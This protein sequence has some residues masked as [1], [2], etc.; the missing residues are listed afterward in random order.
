MRK[1]VKFLKLV[2][3]S[4]I[5]ISSPPK[6]KILIYDAESL[7]IFEK[8]FNE[9][10]YFVLYSRKSVIYPII[11][12]KS[13]FKY[14]SK[15]NL[16]NYYIDLI[17]FVSPEFAFT[18]IDNETFFWKL[19]FL[20]KKKTTTFFIQNGFRNYAHDIFEKLDNSDHDKEKHKVDYY[21]VFSESVKK[22]YEKYMNG[23]GIVIGSFKNNHVPV[24]K[25]NFKQDI[26]FVSEFAS[27]KYFKPKFSSE[28][29]WYPE[30]FFLPI[31]KRFAE[32][33][34]LNL[35]ILGKLNNDKSLKDEEKKF[36]S[37]IIGE[38]G[39]DYVESNK[40]YECYKRIDE[41]KFIIFVSS[42]LGYEAI[43]RNKP[44]AALCARN[45]KYNNHATKNDFNFSWPANI[46]DKGSFW[47]NDCNEE[48]VLEILNYVNNVDYKKWEEETKELRK[49]FMAFDYGNKT[50]LNCIKSLNVP[51]K[52][53][54]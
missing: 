13:I 14:R 49:N 30:N 2:F 35:K 28:D 54:S 3:S 47:T 6:K 27:T 40:Y 25:K 4:K 15:W 7:T 34:N 37:K 45:F 52:I 8:I 48:E 18:R 41:S 10:E 33:N 31:V 38:K 22:R 17:N 16:Y 36:F 46:S 39:W 50:F 5:K 21:F 32:K 44:T 1:I 20:L 42:T 24:I 23:K 53:N 12:I 26:L 9:N 43:A 19:K 11:L 51:L 29:Y